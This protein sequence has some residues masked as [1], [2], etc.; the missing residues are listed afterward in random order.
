MKELAKSNYLIRNFIEFFNK[1]NR[2][3]VNNKYNKIRLKRKRI[4]FKYNK[5]RVKCD[6]IFI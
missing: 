6:R 4:R 2:F 1:Y 5:I 3:R